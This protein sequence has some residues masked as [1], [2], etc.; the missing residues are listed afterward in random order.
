MAM[1]NNTCRDKINLSQIIIRVS[2]FTVKWKPLPVKRTTP[3]HAMVEG[4]LPVS[5]AGLLKLI[6]V[7]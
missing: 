2:T 6:I 5:C 3:L 4:H 7:P 1:F